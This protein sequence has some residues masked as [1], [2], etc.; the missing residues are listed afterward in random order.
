MTV[1]EYFLK[2]YVHGREDDIS[3]LIGFELNASLKTTFAILDK[4]SSEEKNK[5]EAKVNSL[6]MKEKGE[7][8]K[9]IKQ[10]NRKLI[11]L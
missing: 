10:I 5:I 8:T 9:I 4:M 7:S 2:L 11:N 1:K 3:V 6:Y